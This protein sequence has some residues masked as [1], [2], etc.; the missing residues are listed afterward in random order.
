MQ[1]HYKEVAPER[2]LSVYR[3]FVSSWY[4]NEALSSVMHFQRKSS[5]G[6]L[7]IRPFQQRRPQSAALKLQFAF[8]MHIQKSWRLGREGLAG[9]AHLLPGH[10]RGVQGPIN[11]P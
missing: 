9:G 2:S 5:L 6:W 1:C 8:C 7:F 11:P 4:L 10:S 3:N